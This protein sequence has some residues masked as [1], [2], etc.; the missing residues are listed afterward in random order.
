MT[1]LRGGPS[2]D[3]DHLMALADPEGHLMDPLAAVDRVRLTARAVQWVPGVPWVLVDQWADPSAPLTVPVRLSVTA[4]AGAVV[5]GAG[6]EADSET[7]QV[8][9]CVF[10]SHKC[11]L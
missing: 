5:E 7:D 3:R 8:I 6:G 10:V 4:S 1:A 11:D 9:L 2:R